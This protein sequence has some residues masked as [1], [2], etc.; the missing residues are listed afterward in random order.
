MLPQQLLHHVLRDHAVF[1]V[2]HVDASH[3]QVLVFLRG[4]PVP[5]VLAER[6]GRVGVHH[7]NRLAEVL[8]RHHLDHLHVLQVDGHG[9]DDGAEVVDLAH[10]HRLL[11]PLAHLHAEP[12]LHAHRP[13]L[14]PGLVLLVDDQNPHLL[15][16]HL[17]RSLHLAGDDRVPQEGVLQPHPPLLPP[18]VLLLLVAVPF[19]RPRLHRDQDLLPLHRLAHVVV[20]PRHDALLPVSAHAVGGHRDDGYPLASSGRF[21]LSDLHR[22]LPA[23]HYRHVAVHEDAREVLGGG[24]V[25]GDLTIA[26]DCHL[27]APLDQHELHQL[28]PH[29]VVLH[30][31]HVVVHHHLLGGSGLSDLLGGFLPYGCGP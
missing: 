4:Q 2:Q 22:G 16:H 14:L 9:G 12:H 30:H 19:A 31:Q 20:H 17:R 13:Q 15:R 5:V 23:V 29:R 24:N 10:L 25:H 7:R 26:R 28:L 8:L 6:A 27:P 3:Q 11:E 21:S 1:Y 18:G